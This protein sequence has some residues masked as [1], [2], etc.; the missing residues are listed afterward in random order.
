MAT[1]K[2]TPI[3]PVPTLDEVKDMNVWAKLLAARQEFHAV[4]TK[5][6]GINRH[7]EFKYFELADIVPIAEPIFAKYGLLLVPTFPDNRAVAEVINADK[8]EE[9]IEFIIPMQFIAEP[10]KFRMN[11][12][13]GVGAAVTYYRRYLYMVVLNLVEN[14]A[15]D[16]SETAEDKTAPVRKK[17]ATNEE[18]REIKKT[19]TGADGEA[20]ELQKTALKA[21]LKK[22]RE[23]MPEREEFVQEVALKTNGFTSITKQACEKIILT[24]NDLLEAHGSKA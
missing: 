5:K 6:S 12:V 8:P 19:L 18:R 23:T 10:G 21:A 17:P 11:E 2:T 7:A 20:D 14:D 3:E 16:S 13:Q 1:K 15:I 9:K 22:L 4:G 24:V